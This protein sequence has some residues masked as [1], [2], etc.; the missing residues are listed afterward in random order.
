MCPESLFW[1]PWP[2]VSED[3]QIPMNSFLRKVTPFFEHI[4]IGVA[5]A[6]VGYAF[7]WTFNTTWIGVIGMVGICF[8][9]LKV[10]IGL[11]IYGGYI[12][13]LIFRP[14]YLKMKELQEEEQIRARAAEIL[15]NIGRKN[16]ANRRLNFLVR[17]W[18]VIVEVLLLVI[19]VCVIWAVKY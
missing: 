17:N 19:G 18:G 12:V 16:A 6:A 1:P 7:F 14:D 5:Y 11:I 10:L 8:G 2:P 13:A 4:V 15:E 3:L 9:G